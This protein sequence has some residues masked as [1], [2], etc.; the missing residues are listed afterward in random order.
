MENKMGKGTDF[1]FA[2][3]HADTEEGEPSAR[4]QTRHVGQETLAIE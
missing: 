2:I 4:S 1:D 3:Y